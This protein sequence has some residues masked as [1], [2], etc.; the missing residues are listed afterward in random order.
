MFDQ[1]S[2]CTWIA[3]EDVRHLHPDGEE[4]A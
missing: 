1:N 3:V 4:K 2:C